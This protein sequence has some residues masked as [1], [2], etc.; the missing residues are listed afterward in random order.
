MLAGKLEHGGKARTLLSG[1]PYT[2]GDSDVQKPRHRQIHA[3]ALWRWGRTAA[4]LPAFA[5]GFF[6]R[7]RA[8]QVRYPQALRPKTRQTVNDGTGR[9]AVS[10]SVLSGST[11][12]MC[13]KTAL[14]Q[15]THGSPAHAA[16]GIE[17]AFDSG[18]DVNPLMCRIVLDGAVSCS[19]NLGHAGRGQ[20]TGRLREAKP[21]EKRAAS[22][23]LRPQRGWRRAISWRQWYRHAAE[24]AC[25]PTPA[26]SYSVKEPTAFTAEKGS[27]RILLVMK[28]W[29]MISKHRHLVRPSRLWPEIHQQTP[30][31]KSAVQK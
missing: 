20:S 21:E 18:P 25:R 2:I 26:S 1:D 12:R 17:G 9:G 3:A 5:A 19:K 7:R 11:E 24:I 29:L 22:K 30:P 4:P 14:S 15:G 27:G 28:R 6:F 23:P 10:T 16:S 13:P 8:S 31:T